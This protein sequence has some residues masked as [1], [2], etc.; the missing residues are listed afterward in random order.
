MQVKIDSPDPENVAGEILTKGVNLMLGYYKN[1]QATK[2]TFTDD[3]WL[4]TGDLG[5]LDKDNFVFIRGR[6]KNMILG[7]SGQNIYPEEIE[8]RINASPYVEESLAVEE[9]SKIVALIVPNRDALTENGIAESQWEAF[10]KQLVA[11][12]NT[13]LPAYSKL[14]SFRLQSEEFQKTPKRSIKRFI[15]QK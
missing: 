11:E 7:P 1:E 15:Y 3:G 9:E 12:I 14:S 6:D 4:K 2:E 10:F 13:K 8:E 5:T